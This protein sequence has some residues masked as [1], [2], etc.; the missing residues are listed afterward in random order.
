MKKILVLILFGG[1]LHGMKP[2]APAVS[3][4]DQKKQDQLVAAVGKNQIDAVRRLLKF[5]PLVDANAANSEGER[6]LERAVYNSSI[7]IAELLLDNGA[8]PNLKIASGMTPGRT[9]LMYAV[10]NNDAP[11]VRTLIIHGADMDATV[12]EGRGKN[13]VPRKAIDFISRGDQNAH[14]IRNMLT[15]HKIP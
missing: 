14:E 9:L 1:L 7:P 15:K 11:M 6:P 12:N 13:S 2:V 5:K 4:V 10:S 3:K 8:N